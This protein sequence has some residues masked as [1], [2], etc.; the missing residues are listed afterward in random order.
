MAAFVLDVNLQVQKVLGLEAVKQQ[1]AGVDGSAATVGVGVKGAAQSATALNATATAA[2]AAS[3]SIAN[4]G[5]VS[6]K[7]EVEL[8]NLIKSLKL[9]GGTIEKTAGLFDDYGHRVGLAGARYSA[10]IAATAIPFAGLAALGAGVRSIV[11]FDSAMIKLSQILQQP[12]DQIDALREKMIKLSTQTGTSLKEISD[13]ASTLAQAGFLQNTGDFEKF[14]EPLAKVPL[15]PTFKDIGQ[16]TE[17]VIA[18]LGQFKDAALEPIDVLDKLTNVA[19]KFAVESSDLNTALQIAGGTFSQL[20]GSIDEFLA[21]FTTIRQTTRENAS[22]IAT[23]LKT[24]ATRLA[25]PVTIGFLEGIGVAVKNAEGELLGV[26]QI[27]E[28]LQEVFNASGKEQ[29]ARIATQLGGVRNVGRVLA[30]LRNTDLTSDVL[31]ASLT[32]SGT[33]AATAAEGMKKL[34]VQIDQLM[35]RFIELA[36]SLA[37]PLFI[38]LIEGALAFGNAMV[39]V[40]DALGPAIPLLVQLIGVAAGLKI[41]QLAAASIVAFGQ[42]L[43]ALKLPGITAGLTGM[44]N[45]AKDISTTAGGQQAFGFAQPP[46]VAQQGKE[47]VTGTIGQLAGLL[48]VKVATEQLAATF[49]KTDNSVVKLGLNATSTAATLLGLGSLLAGKSVGGLLK[50]GAFGLSGGAIAGGIAGV[51]GVQAI[52]S[53]SDIDIDELVAKAAKTINGLDIKITQGSEEDLSKAV[54]QLSQP[55]G[56]AFQGIADEFDIG[57]FAG[58]ARS[59]ADHLKKFFTLDVDAL[60]LDTSDVVTT[61]GAIT[62][63][64]VEKFIKDMLGSNGEKGNKI[65]SEAIFEFGSDFSSGLQGNLE[66]S[67]APFAGL[68]VDIGKLASK[69][70]EEIVSRAGGI[71]GLAN[72]AREAQ[73]KAENKLL[74]DN[75]KKIADDL[76]NLIIPQQLGGDLRL[77]AEAVKETVKIISS[78]NS[79]FDQLFGTVGKIATPKL[80]TNIGEDATKGLL[81]Q[82]GGEGVF[83]KGNFAQLDKATQELLRSQKGIADFQTAAEDMFAQISKGLGGLDFNNIRVF[84]EFTKDFLAN[85]G[86]ELPPETKKA[87]Q[88]IAP[89]LAQKYSE[90]ISAG[91][92]GLTDKEIESTMEQLFEPLQNIPDVV[93]NSAR[94]LINASNEKANRQLELLDAKAQVVATETIAP[95]TRLDVIAAT[96]DQLGLSASTANTDI[97]RLAQ[98]MREIPDADDIGTTGGRTQRAPFNRNPEQSLDNLATDTKFATEL[99][100]KYAESLAR[101][102]AAQKNYNDIFNNVIPGNLK[103][104]ENAV[105]DANV[106]LRAFKSL[107]IELGR[108]VGVARSN[109][110]K[111]GSQDTPSQADDVARQNRARSRNLDAVQ[112][113][114]GPVAKLLELNAVASDSQIFMDANI[115]FKNSVDRLVSG[116][117]SSIDKLNQFIANAA[118]GTKDARVKQSEP[119]DQKTNGNVRFVQDRDEKGNPTGLKIV[120]GDSDK[121]VN[122]ISEMTIAVNK[123]VDTRRQEDQRELQRMSRTGDPGF[124]P[125]IGIDFK[126]ISN[127]LREVEEA[128]VDLPEMIAEENK[129]NPGGPLSPL[130]TDKADIGKNL[131]FNATKGGGVEIFPSEE[132]KELLEGGIK[133]SKGIRPEDIGGAEND[134]PGASADEIGGAEQFAGGAQMFESAVQFLSDSLAPLDGAVEGIRLANETQ[135]SVAAE[136]NASFLSSL[137]EQISTMLASMQ[138]GGPVDSVAP[139]TPTNDGAAEAATAQQVA[140]TNANSQKLDSVGTEMAGVSSKLDQTAGALAKGISVQVN[141]VQKVNVD[142]TGVSQEIEGI[143]EQFADAARAIAKELINQVLSDLAAAAAS[144]DES[145]NLEGAKLS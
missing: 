31:N 79:T 37:E 2:T 6:N 105:M 19:A 26:T 116:I 72:L 23:A 143:G 100:D 61:G 113:I 126:D 89:A 27:F 145:N 125:N 76:K 128:I 96:I 46:P 4:I 117:S 127:P 62:N 21:I 97:Q 123:L 3:A 24:I 57:T 85:K 38:P 14:L 50:G 69:I 73:K 120:P 43:A 58:F 75:F 108:E 53:Q 70:R 86:L 20:G 77:L 82:G 91:R 34:S 12:Q 56:R 39:T 95:Q 130:G 81:R 104:A 78:E 103:D 98:G 9:S 90:A 102:G 142:V 129:R 60:G 29:Q 80:P 137:S 119:F 124:G 33:V 40:I 131:G 138:P 83:G 10:F 111:G 144:T 74:S 1:L 133:P 18:A 92:A 44:A 64:Q 45:A 121:V 11:E 93:V 5:F 114:L 65:L 112:E 25:Q 55:I 52:T 118:V 132:I 109:P 16:A 87:I 106:E 135:A 67:L 99:T 71:E 47:L 101:S 136:T 107:I 36:Q 110:I 30:G 54:D 15:L 66:K 51:A 141:A 122:K 94:E 32:S 115:I 35:A 7:S 28:N 134:G 8:D 48:A 22:S 139:T 68:G 17:G 13:A 41:F 63:K 59:A 49:D 84:D 140:A 88:G 42:S